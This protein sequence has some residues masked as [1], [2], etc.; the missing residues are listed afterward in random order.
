M[1]ELNKHYRLFGSSDIL[2]ASIWA[3]YG[4][5][6]RSGN[7]SYALLQVCF[8]IKGKR[9]GPV[10]GCQRFAIAGAIGLRI[11]SSASPD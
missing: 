8:F 2:V 4:F 5:S 1:N 11:F 9:P 6:A 7:R 3:K 10:L